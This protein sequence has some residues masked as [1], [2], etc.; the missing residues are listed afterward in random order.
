MIHPRIGERNTSPKPPDDKEVRKEIEILKMPQVTSDTTQKEFLY[1]FLDDSLHLRINR[2]N[3]QIYSYKGDDSFKIQF[4][5][6]NGSFIASY[7]NKNLW[8]RI[9]GIIQL[10]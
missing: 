3:T 8:L 4:I 9:L 7:K 5:T 10:I 2:P 1:I 6:D